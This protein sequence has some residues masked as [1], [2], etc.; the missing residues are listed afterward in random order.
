MMQ[1]F[2]DRNNPNNPSPM[3]PDEK[4]AQQKQ[5]DDF[6][7]AKKANPEW[8]VGDTYV[9]TDD[10]A[11]AQAQAQQAQQQAAP[12]SSGNTAAPA[13]GCKFCPECGTK[14]EGMKFCPNCGKKLM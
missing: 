10:K 6:A 8:Y 11:K 5:Y 1:G 9:G 12:A 3:S 2:S 13:G 4:A 14:T 7:A